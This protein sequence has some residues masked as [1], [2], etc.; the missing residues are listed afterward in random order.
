MQFTDAIKRQ[1]IQE[2]CARQLCDRWV[3]LAGKSSSS[4]SSNSNSS[5]NCNQ[6]EVPR[7]A[8]PMMGTMSVPTVIYTLSN[9]AAVAVVVRRS[10]SLYCT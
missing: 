8:H 7:V 10:L 3:Q 2:W 6:H 5:I 4:S 9:F 1:D